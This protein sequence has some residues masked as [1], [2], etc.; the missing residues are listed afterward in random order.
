M[1]RL[2]L[3]VAIPFIRVLSVSARGQKYGDAKAGTRPYRAERLECGVFHRFPSAGPSLM[4]LP[5]PTLPPLRQSAGIPRTPNASRQGEAA[6]RYN[7]SPLCNPGV[8]SR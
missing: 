7:T 5:L 8:E 2:S 1:N 4:S 3:A 6:G